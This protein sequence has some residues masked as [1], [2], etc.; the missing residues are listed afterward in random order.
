ME[1]KIEFLTEQMVSIIGDI[2]KITEVHDQEKLVYIMQLENLHIKNN[3]YFKTTPLVELNKNNITDIFYIS[4]NEE[5]HIK[6]LWHDSFEEG[7]TN[8]FHSEFYNL[9][10]SVDVQGDLVK[11]EMVR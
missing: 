4:N 6:V 1:K 11:L 9:G 2:N 3:D 5:K 8:A 7:E 10:Q